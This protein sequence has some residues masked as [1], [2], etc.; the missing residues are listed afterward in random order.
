MVV[1]ESAGNPGAR[2]SRWQVLDRA[3]AAVLC[4]REVVPCE[5]GLQGTLGDDR[6]EREDTRSLTS[7]QEGQEGETH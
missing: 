2:Q 5:A 4:R 3:I 1:Y 6:V 7:I